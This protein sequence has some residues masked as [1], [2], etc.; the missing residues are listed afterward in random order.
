M[1]DGSM[2][3]DVYQPGGNNEE[4]EDAGPLDME[5]AL[6]EDD[7]DDILGKG[8]SPPERPYAVDKTGTTAAEQRTGESLDERLAEEVPEVAEDGGDGLGDAQDTDGEPVDAEAGGAR[9][10][11]L[12]S[13]GQG[14]ERPTLDDVTAED[15]G[16]DGAASSA[17]EAA[18]HI[19]EDPEETP[20][21]R[22]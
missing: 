5:D 11:R 20:G 13:P 2:G 10:G 19:V 1:S 17:E 6:D 8:Y 9:A 14:L 22:A 15:V 16:I 12:V 3:D 18:V 21:E 4:Q 7:Y